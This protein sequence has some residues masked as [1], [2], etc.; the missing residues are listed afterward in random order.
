MSTQAQKEFHMETGQKV[1]ALIL[2][3]I[4]LLI[5]GVVL[6]MHLIHGMFVSGLISLVS[7]G[8]L[9]WSIITGKLFFWR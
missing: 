3:L 4:P 2:M 7:T 5:I 6:D 1:G 9:Y 8:L